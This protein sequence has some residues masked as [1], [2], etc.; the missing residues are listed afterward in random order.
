[1]MA[2]FFIRPVQYNP[3]LKRWE[4]CP[5]STAPSF[6]VIERTSEGERAV[7]YGSTREEARSLRDD[8]TGHPSSH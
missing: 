7:A 8:L 1:M 6:A 3:R 4:E 2:E 5:P